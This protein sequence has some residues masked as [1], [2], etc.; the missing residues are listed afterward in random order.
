MPMARRETQSKMAEPTI[1]VNGHA[2][3]SAQAMAVR[4]A[5]SSFNYELGDDNHGQTMAIAYREKLTEVL[6]MMQLTA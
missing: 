1:I 3:T 4:V 6:R 5:V 2:L